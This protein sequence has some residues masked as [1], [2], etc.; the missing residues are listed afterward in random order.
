MTMTTP[1]LPNLPT[2]ENTKFRR[3]GL[4]T[5]GG[6]APGMNAAVRAVVRTAAQHGIEAVGIRRGFTGLYEGDMSLIGPRDV[7][8]IIQRGGTMLLTARSEAWRTPAGRTQGAANLHE[9]NVDGL[10]VIGGDGSFHGA[11]ALQEEHGFPVVGIPGTIDND[12]YGTDYTIGYHTAVQTALEAVDKLRDTG[13]SHERIFVIE[14]MGRH[15]GHIAVEVALAGG[16]EEVLVPERP[17]ELEEV[18]GIVEKSLERGKR[19]SIIIVAEGFPGGAK[20]VAEA[21]TAVTGE[22]TRETILGHIQRG[23]VP[24]AHDRVLA[25][26]L[27]QAAV[28][29]LLSGKSD[30]MV[31]EV[32]G[33]IQYVPLEDTWTKRKDV[34]ASKYRCARL[35]SI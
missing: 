27:G 26:V 10:V 2:N 18:V 17:K 6:D 7:A 24:L 19:S 32:G 8:N 12:L 16:A 29:A 28:E 34:M 23:G 30:V 14:V 35:L 22:E 31:G 25:S 13:A 15:A 3:I 21:I 33:D 11:H 20:A 1:D 9:W 5:S 4:L